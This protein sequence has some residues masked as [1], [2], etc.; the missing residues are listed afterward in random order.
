MLKSLCGMRTAT[1]PGPGDY[2]ILE[3]GGPGVPPQA[4]RR[5]RAGWADAIVGDNRFTYW[6][7]D[8]ATGEP[9]TGLRPLRRR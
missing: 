9:I 7:A 5:L 1:L 2:E 4:Q 6:F 8:A 3:G